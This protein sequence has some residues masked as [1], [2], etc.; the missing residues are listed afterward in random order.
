[1]IILF[2]AVFGL[3]FGSFVNAL[4]YRLHEQAALADKRS[5]EAQAR[6]A[7]LSML[8]GRSMCSHCGHTLASKDLVPVFSWLWL[9]GRCRYCRAKIND[10]PLVE[11]AL[12]VLFVLSY[13]YWPQPVRGG[14]WLVLAFWLLFLVGA[15]ALA[16]Y[17][18]RWSLLP[19]KLIYPLYG[20]ALA[21]VIT[22]VFVRHDDYLMLS[23]VIGAV[24]LGGLFFSLYRVSHEA[25]LGGGDVKLVP[26]LGLLAGGVLKVALLLLI[27]SLLGTL[28]SLPALA[29]NGGNLKLKIPFGPFLL[30]ATLVIVLFGQKLADLL[31]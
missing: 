11:L 17:D 23:S 30:V 29:K 15:L 12:P 24:I 14:E 8:H 25:W 2:L 13:I 22:T 31:V 6:R 21:Q 3:I 4:V 18:A 28:W 26:I 19:D 27:A 10:S 5:K 16:V 1:M 7:Q 9:R 20:V